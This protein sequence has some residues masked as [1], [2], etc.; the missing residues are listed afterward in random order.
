MKT[1]INK[2]ILAFAIVISFFA[3]SCTDLTVENLNEP[4]LLKVFNTPEDLRNYAGSAFRT[5]HNAMQEY[6]SPA[7]AMNTMADQT[8][9]SWGTAGQNALSSEPRKGFTNIISFYGGLYIDVFGTI[10]MNPSQ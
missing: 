1:R 4:D 3:N 10:V 9:C 8:T 2:I 7:L 6:D 5:L